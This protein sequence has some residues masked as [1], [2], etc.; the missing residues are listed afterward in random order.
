[1][2]RELNNS[3]PSARRR[4]PRE[5]RAAALV[6]TVLMLAG[7]NLAVVSAVTGGGDDAR[8]ASTRADTERAFYAAESGAALVVGE[9]A[10]G[11]SVPT[12]TRTIA[13]GASVTIT[14]SAP[15]APMDVVIIGAFGQAQRR[16]EISIQ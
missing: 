13:G 12:G 7:I 10:A 8:L 9:Y 16:V 2:I 14:A 1:M 15:S 3:L 11:R 6:M 5:R 4:A